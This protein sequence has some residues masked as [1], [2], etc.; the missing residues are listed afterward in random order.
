MLVVVLLSS[1]WM[2]YFGLWGLQS[3][4]GYGHFAVSAMVNSL[5][6]S[7]NVHYTYTLKAFLC[8]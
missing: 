8:L 3:F 5:R 4:I 2:D 7:K 1:G 6:A